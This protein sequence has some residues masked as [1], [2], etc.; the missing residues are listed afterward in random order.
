M[1]A[2]LYQIRHDQAGAQDNKKREGD[3]IDQK[4]EKRLKAVEAKQRLP[5]GADDARQQSSFQEICPL[6]PGSRDRLVNAGFVTPDKDI[7]SCDHP[8]KEIGV[9]ASHQAKIPIEEIF[10]VLNDCFR[11]EKI[12]GPSLPGIGEYRS[13]GKG[14]PNEQSPFDHPGRWKY[15]IRRNDRAKNAVGAS[16]NRGAP[17]CQE[18]VL[19]GE[20][21]I[22]YAGNKVPVS[23]AQGPIPRHRNILFRLN[24]VVDRNRRS[25]LYLGNDIPCGFFSVIIDDEDV[26]AEQSLA[27]LVLKRL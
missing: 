9:F 19:F 1:V 6:E 5:L 27:L 17:Q 23:H 13:R 26:I 10:A 3:R 11:D 15:F 4:S 2:G 25:R 12:P 22:I 14:L 7:F 24:G 20:F 18:P 21:I 8:S 16:L